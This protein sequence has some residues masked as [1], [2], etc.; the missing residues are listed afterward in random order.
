MMELN[1]TLEH[2]C[3]RV[4]DGMLER[5]E[6]CSGVNLADCRSGSEIRD[7]QRYYKDLRRTAV[8]SSFL[9]SE[10]IV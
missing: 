8:Q 6:P 2:R 9:F 3:A 5:P 10:K 1:I 7:R 4:L